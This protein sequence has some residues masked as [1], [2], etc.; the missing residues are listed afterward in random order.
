MV[1]DMIIGA[2]LYTLR[3]FCQTPEAFAQTLNRVAELGYKTVQVSGTCAYEPAWL[4]EQLRAAGLSCLLTHT[5]PDRIAKEP[6]AVCREHSV[7]DCPYIGIGWYDLRTGEAVQRFLDEFSGAMQTLARQ[8]KK[9]MYHNHDLEFEHVGDQTAL[10][11]LAEQTAPEAL[12]FTLDTYWVQAGGGDPAW[13]LRHL[14]GRVPCVHYKD[15]GYGRKML[16]V[17]AGNMNFEAIIQASEEA[18]VDY[19]FVEQDDC[20]G[21]DPFDCLAMSFDYLTACGLH[22]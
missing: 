13:W 11:L 16:P 18:G 9:L 21:K 17:G 3:E 1:R 15:M 2:Q 14:K 22:A 6:E 12:G 5:P 20:N 4:K 10:A 19:V 7:F 8:G